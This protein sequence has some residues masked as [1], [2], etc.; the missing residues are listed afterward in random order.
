MQQVLLPLAKVGGR[1]GVRVGKGIEYF[2]TVKAL[3]SDALEHQSRS[4]GQI[5]GGLPPQSGANPGAVAIVDITGLAGWTQ[6]IYK[7]SIL[8]GVGNYPQG[9]IFPR[10]YVDHALEVA[11]VPTICDGVHVKLD[12]GFLLVQRRL[13][14]DVADCAAH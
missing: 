5:A 9:C 1:G 10:G 4:Y 13:V 3:C 7:A 8:C 11:A 14:G 2:L 6:G 12:G